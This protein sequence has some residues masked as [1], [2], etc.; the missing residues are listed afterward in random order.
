M[1]Q[2]LTLL[3]DVTNNKNNLIY[4]LEGVLGSR[5]RG[6]SPR[7]DLFSFIHKRLSI[8]HVGNFEFNIINGSLTKSNVYI[9]DEIN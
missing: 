4:T 8:K 2:I 5:S 6:T 1:I 3:R 7:R 9:Y